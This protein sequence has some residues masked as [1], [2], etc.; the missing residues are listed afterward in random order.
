MYDLQV[1]NNL[2]DPLSRKYYGLNTQFNY[3]PFQSL[4]LGGNWTWSH[5]YGNF[6]GETTGSGPIQSIVQQYPEY[7]QQSWNFP[8]GD[9]PQDQRHRVRLFGTFDM[10][11]PKAMGL[12]SISAIQAYDSGLP[13]GAVGKVRAQNYVTNPGY[14]QPPTTVTYYYSSRDAFTT[15]SVKRTDLALNWSYKF[16]GLVEVFIQPQIIN[17][18]NYQQ[19]ATNIGH[20]HDDQDAT[21]NTRLANFNP[22]TTTPNSVRPTGRIQIPFVGS[23]RPVPAQRTTASR[24]LSAPP[25]ALPPISSPARTGSRRASASDSFFPRFFESPGT[26]RGFFLLSVIVAP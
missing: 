7:K 11:V 10:P 19:I 9:L 18:F 8:T 4:S 16:G 20:Q 23:A 1:I 26:R 24:R 6:V 15:P 3:R 17:V 25:P 13:Y 14:A 22:F 2:S 12:W 5:T 21:T